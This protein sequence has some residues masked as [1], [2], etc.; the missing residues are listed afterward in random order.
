MPQANIDNLIFTPSMINSNSFANQPPSY[1]TPNSGGTNT[2]IFHSRAGDLHTPGGCAMGLGTS[3][4]TL[5]PEPG[6]PSGHTTQVGVAGFQ[7]QNIAPCL[8]QSQQLFSYQEVQQ[9]QHSQQ[10]YA[11]HPFSQQQTI[12]KSFHDQQHIEPK[13]LHYS[14]DVKLQEQQVLEPLGQSSIT[15]P[16]GKGPHQAAK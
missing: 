16:I 14:A 7:P 15:M 3:L 9:T 5:K 12:S 1:C 8:F 2:I 13:I 6:A 11:P 10:S 4:S